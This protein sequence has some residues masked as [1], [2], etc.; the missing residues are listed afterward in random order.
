M[1]LETSLFG[2]KLP[3]LDEKV[4]IT[5]YSEISVNL[6]TNFHESV[7]PHNSNLLITFQPN[8]SGGFRVHSGVKFVHTRT[9]A[10]TQT[11]VRHVPNY[12][13]FAGTHTV[14]VTVGEALELLNLDAKQ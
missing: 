8:R 6:G 4:F 10:R 12:T 5:N 1:S 2:C 9:H 11:L 3:Y 13:G 14:V 7:I